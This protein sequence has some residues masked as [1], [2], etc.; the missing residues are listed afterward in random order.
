VEKTGRW[1][2]SVA[3]GGPF[4][5][6][7]PGT[8]TT[9]ISQ[10]FDPITGPVVPVFFHY[11][12]PSVLGMLAATSAGVIDGMFIGNFV[13]SEALA[14][15]NIALPVWAVFSAVVFMLAVG[16]SVVCG[17]ALGEGDRA[18]ASD[19]FTRTFIATVG[20][21]VLI[22]GGCL[23][24]LEDAVRLLG[25]N[26][27]IAPM[28]T[29]Y[30]RIILWFAPLLIA[31]LTLYYF[32]RVDGRPVLAAVGLGGFSVAN[33][34]LNALFIVV[35]GW[36]I[37]GAAWASALADVF[38]FAILITHL[39]H[40]RCSLRLVRVDRR[41]GVVLR[42][43]WN[44]FSE[45]ANELSIGL[46]VL[47]FNWVMITR[48]GVSGVAAYTIIG[49]LVML[50]LEV[51]YG[52]SE[53]LQPTVSKNLGARQPQRIRQYLL[54]GLASAL[55]VGVTASA[56]FVFLPEAMVGLFLG[57]AEDETLGIALEFIAWFWPAFL[58]NGMNLTFASY[59]TAL[60]RPV[61]SAAIALSRSLLLPAAGL[62][63]LP[64]WLGDRGIFLAIPLAEAMTFAFALGLVFL[65]PPRFDANPGDLE[66]DQG[67]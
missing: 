29:Q 66:A 18:A 34:A 35:L 38:M 11:A 43:A 39:F 22:S 12:V 41:W 4:R 21:G 67:E 37:E 14:A 15:V 46:V 58:F 5:R 24:F 61:P 13:G 44:G 56:L 23:L 62:L 31:G 53:S 20:L 6:I 26:A 32:V 63:L 7:L 36:G 2:R 52:I 9:E 51:C 48:L 40:R 8:V 65:L 25:A 54:L 33:I 47:L 45:F 27:E 60:H 59:F 55:A 16:G 19:V 28:V 17:K 50:G 49:Y 42:A 30:M 10:R 1:L 64:L 57:D 3:S